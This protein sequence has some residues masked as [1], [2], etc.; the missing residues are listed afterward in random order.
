MSKANFFEHDLGDFRQGLF[1]YQRT[2][3]NVVKTSTQYNRTTYEDKHGNEL[4]RT[5]EHRN[6]RTQ[7]Q[8][9]RLLQPHVLEG[10]KANTNLILKE[11]T[12]RKL[13]STRE[14]MGQERGDKVTQIESARQA[15]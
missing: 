1:M 12:Y 15:T 2:K 13:F 3:G 5:F 4:G 11:D 9:S 6:G 10:Q 8:A 14:R 7:C